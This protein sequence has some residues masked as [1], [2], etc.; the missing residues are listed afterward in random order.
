MNN[1]Y[2]QMGVTEFGISEQLNVRMS[3]KPMLGAEQVWVRVLASSVNPI[4]IKTRSGHGYV[5]QAKLPGEFLPLGYDLLGV[6]EQVGEDVSDIQPG[7]T[8]LGMVGFPSSPGCYASHVIASS[9][10]IICVEEKVS[11]D[12]AGLSLAGLTAVQA[13]S[14]LST[15]NG[16]LYINAPTGGVGHLAVQIAKNIGFDVVAVTNRGDLIA[17]FEFEL[18][19]IHY[20]DFFAQKKAGQLLDLVG[21]E[22][23]KKMLSNMERGS[24]F[25][26]VPTVTK[27]DV[28]THGHSLEMRGESVLVAP[29]CQQLNTLYQAVVNN[30][31]KVVV[32]EKYKLD[33][34]SQAHT[35]VEQGQH[36]GKVIIVA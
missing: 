20:D 35:F 30:Q 3:T 14:K 7:D 21:G 19:Y 12:I 28:I 2:K 15:S 11:L 18:P 8:V 36:F 25:V 29:N 4:D 24:F 10:Q 17:S 5:A 6:V 23:A 26:T 31:L 27:D 13:L 16:T 32:S 33:E 22:I 1:Q 9:E 34:L